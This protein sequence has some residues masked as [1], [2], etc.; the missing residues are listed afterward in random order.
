MNPM[1]DIRPMYFRKKPVE[2]AAM[3]F[4]T[5]NDLDFANMNMIVNWLNLGRDTVAAWHNGVSIF[6]ESPWGAT[7][8]EVGDWII[9][10]REG[11]V[12]VCAPDVFDA[13][14]EAVPHD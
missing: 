5:N 9:R 4:V 13:T 2:V 12:S 6:V 10:E 8:A 7:R 3:H 14:Y 11:E 1:E